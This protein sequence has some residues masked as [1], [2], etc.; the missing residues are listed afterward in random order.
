MLRLAA[1]VENREVTRLGL[2]RKDSTGSALTGKRLGTDPLRYGPFCSRGR[3]LQLSFGTEPIGV[4]RFRPRLN[5]RAP[6]AGQLFLTA[7]QNYVSSQL[8][9]TAEKITFPVSFN[10]FCEKVSK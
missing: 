9:L 8:F 3:G 2:H 1:T 5:H 7:G 6:A 10:S 4:L